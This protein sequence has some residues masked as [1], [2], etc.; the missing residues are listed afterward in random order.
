MKR[1]HDDASAPPLSSLPVDL[2]S[3][4]TDVATALR[5]A[6]R[7]RT[8]A[9]CDAAREA[10]FP[11]LEAGLEH[12]AYAPHAAAYAAASLYFADARLRASASRP[13]LAHQAATDALRALDLAILR[14]GIELWA[15]HAESLIL[16]AGRLQ[17]EATKR[18][19]DP[20]AASSAYSSTSASEAATVRRRHFEASCKHF[21]AVGGVPIPRVDASS[22]STEAF[23]AQYMEGSIEA[24][25][26]PVILCGA[27]DEWPA[28][29]RWTTAYLV[30]QAGTRLVPVETYAVADATSTYLSDSWAQR[31]MSLSEYIE[32][33]VEGAPDSA[34]AHSANEALGGSSSAPKPTKPTK[35]TKPTKPT[36]K[37]MA[38]RLEATAAVDEVSA[39]KAHAA[40]E[41]AAAACGYLAQ[42]QLFDQIPSLREDILTP[43]FCSARTA[44]DEGA[45][46]ECEQPLA[47][48]VS[49]WFG[50]A[51]TVSPLHTDPYHNT[52]AQVVGHKYVR[53]YEA[54]HTSRLY[55]RSGAL[56][57]N[58]HVDLDQP[59]PARQPLVESTPFMHCILAPGELL[60]IPRH[61]WHYVRSLETSFSVSFWWGAKMALSLRADGCVEARY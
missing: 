42:Y 6:E 46:P 7:E 56:C 5:A 17:R 2:A 55:P 22:L 10:T 36:A 8:E 48:I 50:P 20:D 4:D 58:C 28:L 41:E 19:S 45:P 11:F 13:K 18:T 59:Q 60:Y 25:P 44:E 47:P 61:V 1:P 51:G 29:R 27:L 32:R 12:A 14:G 40:D 43:R 37:A 31:V 39:D 9:A 21:S 38:A 33:Y 23:R 30:E 52:L 16:A 34:E 3:L 53:L 24:P 35:S 54:R 15:P 57:N 49:A 26:R